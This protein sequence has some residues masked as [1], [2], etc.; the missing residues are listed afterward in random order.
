[1]KQIFSTEIVEKNRIFPYT[2]PV[3]GKGAFNIDNSPKPLKKKHLVLITAL[4][5]PS[6]EPH[7]C[8]SRGKTGGTDTGKK[9]YR[10]T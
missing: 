3:Y 4:C 9:D 6:L 10:N 2:K 8:V 7:F 5:C 1:L